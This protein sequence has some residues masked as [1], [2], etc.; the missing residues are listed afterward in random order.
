M[1]EFIDIVLSLTSSVVSLPTGTSALTDCGLIPALVQTVSRDLETAK[2]VSVKSPFAIPPGD[3]GKTRG[4]AYVDSLLKF[5][6]AQAI[7]ILEAAVVTHSSA[8]IAFHELE[9]VELLVKRLNLEI[10]EIKQAGSDG[11]SDGDGDSDGDVEVVS[12][13]AVDVDVGVA[14]D[15][16]VA[17]DITVAG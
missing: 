14:V 3:E 8:L 6:S 13:D 15:V 16:A 9:G 1:L 17:V 4:T 12:D 10:E 2:S 5:V 11:N 7:Q